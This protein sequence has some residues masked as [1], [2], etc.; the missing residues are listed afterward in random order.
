MSIPRS[1]SEMRVARRN[2]RAIGKREFGRV[3]AGGR[4]E[5]A[6]SRDAADRREADPFAIPVH[7]L[8]RSTIA[9]RLPVSIESRAEE[10]ADQRR[11]RDEAG[12]CWTQQFGE[13][14]EAGEE[15]QAGEDMG[16]ERS[17]H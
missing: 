11:G 14:P 7:D 9:H 2:D 10:G 1:F 5:P 12:H 17:D 6:T 8:A 3:S 15:Y 13:E 4:S 16:E